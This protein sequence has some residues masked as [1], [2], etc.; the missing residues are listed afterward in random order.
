MKLMTKAIEARFAKLG[1]QDKPDAIVVAKYFALGS[2]WTWY[3]TEYDPETGL[4]FGLVD[5]FE[6]ELGSFALWELEQVR[7]MGIP[8]VERDLHWQ[9]Q[10][11]E[12]VRRR[13]EIMRG[14]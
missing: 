3:A 2:S 11:V 13:C 7:W 6:I 4:M 10:T 9:E 1:K 5:G 14:Q 12:L 8:G